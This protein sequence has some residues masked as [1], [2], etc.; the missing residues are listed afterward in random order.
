[1]CIVHVKNKNLGTGRLIVSKHAT[2]NS[3]TQKQEMLTET[4]CGTGI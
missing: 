1:M 4:S 2:K 3:N